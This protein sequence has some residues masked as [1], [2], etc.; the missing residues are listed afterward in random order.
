M[1]TAGNLL[2]PGQV[3]LIKERGA[4]LRPNVIK[5]SSVRSFLFVANIDILFN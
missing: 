3:F 1:F 5:L 2:N 4:G